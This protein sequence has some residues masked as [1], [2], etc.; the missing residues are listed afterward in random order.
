M[1]WMAGPAQ[2]I[3]CVVD[4]VIEKMVGKYAGVWTNVFVYPKTA[5]VIHCGL[6]WKKAVVVEV[7]LRL[8]PD[9]QFLESVNNT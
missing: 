5:Y 8:M 2:T 9:G 1:Y 4:F 3:K 7:A 6:V